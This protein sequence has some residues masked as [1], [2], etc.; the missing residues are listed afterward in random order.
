[1]RVRHQRP[2]VNAK[3]KQ[4][5]LDHK[6][7]INEQSRRRWAV[8]KERYGAVAKIWRED[9]REALLIYFRDRG[10]SHRALTDELKSC[11][12]LDCGSTFPPFSMEFDH[13]QGE[14]R[15]AL[16]KMANHSR[17]AV[18]VELAKCELV[19]C[20]CH[21]IRTDE[22]RATSPN[23]KVRAFHEWLQPLKDRPCLDC[24]QNFPSV[25][26]DF[27][28][29]RGEKTSGISQMWSWGRDRVLEE[30]AKCDLVCANCHRVRTQ[31]RRSLNDDVETAA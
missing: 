20:V 4:Y 7:K 16:G 18:E 6:T 25:A 13:V 24:G 29:V 17:E 10:A 31:N 1:M 22:R 30:I 11:P 26:M 23:P 8:N 28:H 12:C 2:D 15:H 5:Y 3:V 9:N 14:K 19:C 21:R 27:D